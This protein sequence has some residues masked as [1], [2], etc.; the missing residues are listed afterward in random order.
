[1]VP[2]KTQITLK[3]QFPFTMRQTEPRTW[4]VKFTEM[5]ANVTV[6]EAKFKKPAAE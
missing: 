1:M 2:M 4:T 5:K 6:D 3:R